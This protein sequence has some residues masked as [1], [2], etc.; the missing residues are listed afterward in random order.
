M[1]RIFLKNKPAI[2][3]LESLVLSRRDTDI[4]DA[5]WAAHDTNTHEHVVTP[6][7]HAPTHSSGG[8]EHPGATAS[9]AWCRGGLGAGRWRKA[10]NKM[11]VAALSV[12]L[13]SAVLMTKVYSPTLV[14]LLL[15][16]VIKFKQ[17]LPEN[18]IKNDPKIPSKNEGFETSEGPFPPPSA[19]SQ[20]ERKKHYRKIEFLCRHPVALWSGCILLHDIICTVQLCVTCIGFCLSLP[21]SGEVYDT[22]E[23][24][25]LQ[26]AAF[27]GC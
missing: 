14:T 27:R 4:S 6:G 11:R 7:G 21:V 8:Q 10:Q 5:A 9:G 16:V 23:K 12:A 15:A 24:A 1:S 3:R 19:F 22:S 26:K 2:P 18:Y 13:C 25:H 20:S 17:L